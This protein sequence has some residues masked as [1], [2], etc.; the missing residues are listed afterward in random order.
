MIATV[1]ARR[2]RRGVPRAVPRMSSTIPKHPEVDPERTREPK[3]FNDDRSYSGQDYHIKDEAALGD[4]QPS[5]AATSWTP[6]PAD[7]GATHGDRDLPPA[8]AKPAGADP[9]TG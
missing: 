9:T 2:N 1:R 7:S 4:R 5:G 3:P 8:A 6:G